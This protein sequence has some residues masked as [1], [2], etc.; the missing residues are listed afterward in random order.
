MR[1]RKLGKIDLMVILGTRPEATKLAPVILE[2]RR[3]P[4]EFQVEIIATGQHREML[5]QALAIFGVAPD[6]SLNI[7]KRNQS[8]EH[9]SSAALTR[10]EAVFAS[11]RPDLVLVEGDTTTVFAAALAAFYHHIPAAHLEAGLRTNDLYNPFPEE[12]NRRLCS[13]LASLH[14][15]PTQAAKENLLAEGHDPAS[16]YVTG[17]TAVDA[18][19]W[20]A[21][22][23][24]P[25]L[26][27]A[28]QKAKKMLLVTAHRR[29]NWGEPLRRICL[30]LLEITRRFP[31][32][33]VFFPVHPNPR[34][35]KTV[36]EVLSG[37]ERIHLLKPMDYL[38]FVHMMRKSYLI[39]TD[40]GGLQ[41]E[42]PSLDKP[43]L[44]LREKTERAEGL[45]AGT[46]RLVGTDAGRIVREAS[47]LL[48]DEGAYAAMARAANPFGDGRAAGRV[49]QAI[50][51]YLG[52]RHRRPEE[53]APPTDKRAG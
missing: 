18:V 34:V 30:A 29:E 26:P 24:C 7:M 33:E 11:R 4:A 39:L 41:E 3:P 43:V 46:S 27:K 42:A 31:E 36:G 50:L 35:R 6:R 44:V 52:R 23:P 17:N 40:S 28:V 20:C 37:K 1:D 15:A 47:R 14:L 53:F 49:R 12:I 32:V 13:V 25:A 48:R 8:L 2:L 22:R 10:L 38:P 9:I 45:A 16:L 5:P 21:S 51:H 19:L